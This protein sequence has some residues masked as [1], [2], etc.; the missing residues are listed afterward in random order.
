MLIYYF[1]FYLWSVQGMAVVSSVLCVQKQYQVQ[2]KNKD[3]KIFF[4]FYQDTY[5]ST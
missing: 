4:L 3:A 5:K 1:S 2:E